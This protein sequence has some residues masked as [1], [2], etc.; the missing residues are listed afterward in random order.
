MNILI[1]DDNEIKANKIKFLVSEVLYGKSYEVI[2]SRNNADAMT[3]LLSRHP[4]AL[5]ILDMNLP[6]RNGA[7]IKKLAGLKLLNEIN[8]RADINKPESIIGLTAYKSEEIK[9]K[10]LFDNEGWS[11]IHFDL[12]TGDWELTI[13]NKLNYLSG[14]G[15]FCGSAIHGMKKILFVASSPDDQDYL[16]AGIEQRK[17]DEMLKSSTLRA[18]FELISKPGAKL[19]TLTRELMQNNPEFVHFSGHGDID[20]IAM[21]ED[22]GQTQYIPSIALENLFKLFEGKIHCV[23][24]SACYSAKQAKA[25][26]KSHI[27]VIGMNSAIGVT[28]ATELAKGFYQAIGE[29]KDIPTAYKFGLIHLIANDISQQNIPQIWFDGKKL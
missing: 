18:S 21:E 11:I 19:D 9:S 10:T 5:M 29:G 8:R 4:I 20:G 1:V 12:K 14:K 16:N 28:T 7:E 17:I 27:Y 22:N 6:V 13:R 15:Y 3:V 25:I 26:S 2:V 23:F 24:L